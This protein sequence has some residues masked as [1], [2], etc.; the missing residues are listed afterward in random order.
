[1]A[2]CAQGPAAEE[3]ALRPRSPAA[4][5]FEPASTGESDSF[6]NTPPRLAQLSMPLLNLR[7][8]E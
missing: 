3:H 1:M 2:L 6:V 5:S 8:L 7:L 4:S